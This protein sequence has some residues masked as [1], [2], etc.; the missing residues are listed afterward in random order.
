MIRLFP[1]SEVF[2]PNQPEANG[3]HEL[4]LPDAFR[5]I[6][7]EAICWLPAEIIARLSSPVLRIT[8][9]AGRS[10][11]FLSVYMDGDFLA[12]QQI[13]RY[14][15][16]YYHVPSEGLNKAGLV[17]ICLRVD[18]VESSESDPRILGLPICGVD[19][20]DLN[21]GWDGF[22]ERGAVP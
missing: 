17:E 9:T 14:G 2:V 10:E 4:E 6:K 21:S 3:F 13:D 1:S 15:S 11:R 22:D 8:A 12:T 20:I 18:R 7:Q 19:A 5:W 16:Y